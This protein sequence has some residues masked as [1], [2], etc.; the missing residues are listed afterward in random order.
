[1]KKK[2]EVK[3]TKTN[4]FLMVLGSLALALFTYVVVMM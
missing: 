3:F 4:K 2:D 1:M